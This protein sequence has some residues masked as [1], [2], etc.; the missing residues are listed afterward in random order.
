MSDEEIIRKRIKKLKGI[1][2]ELD[3]KQLERELIPLSG[4]EIGIKTVKKKRN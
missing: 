3:E 1:H 4:E 2:P